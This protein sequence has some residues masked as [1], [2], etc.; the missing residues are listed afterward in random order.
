MPNTRKTLQEMWLMLC[1]KK[2]LVRFMFENVNAPKTNLGNNSSLMKAD[3]LNNN[4]N[5]NSLIH[6]VTQRLLPSILLLNE[7]NNVYSN[8]VITNS[9]NA[10]SNV[11]SSNNINNIGKSAN[12]LNKT[13][14]NVN[15]LINMTS[16]VNT[17]SNIG[18]S[19]TNIN[20]NIFSI[21]NITSKNFSKAFQQV[22]DNLVITSPIHFSETSYSNFTL[23]NNAITNNINNPNV[24]NTSNINKTL[25]ANSS[26][27][28]SNMTSILNN[29]SST[30]NNKSNNLNSAK[31][32]KKS[33]KNITS[34]IPNPQ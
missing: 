18:T 21:S 33:N 26:S 19:V 11:N 23:V 27:N 3:E 22:K 29:V 9:I 25:L 6:N 30:I 12:A 16:N 2:D 4:I 32:S 10:S 28:T 7:Q 14:N 8:A 5:K 34:N 24:P 17:L 20:N 1:K 31:S 13:T 15:N